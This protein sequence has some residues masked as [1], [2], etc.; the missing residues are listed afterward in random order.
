MERVILIAGLL[1]LATLDLAGQSGFVPCMPFGGQAAVD[2]L[3]ERELVFPEDALNE[4]VDGT[5]TLIFVVDADGTVHD[6]RVWQPLS[7]SCDAEALRL[8][9]LVRWHPATLDGQPRAA[10]HYLKVPFD[11]KHYR[12]WLKSRGALCPPLAPAPVDRSGAILGRNDVDSLPSPILPGGSKSLPAHIVQ[13]LRYPQD[14]YR[15]DLQG[16]VRLEFIVETSGSISNLRALDELGAGCTDEAMRLI[17]S[18]C[19][20]PAVKDG[21]RV[22][23]TQVISID[24]RIAPNQH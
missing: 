8:A 11:P 18:L 1:G 6:L 10:E 15:R 9:R 12:K 5:S 4:G 16:T 24:F 21:K 13:N 23:G 20:E 22:R 14:A 3:F 17:R 2:A 19:W 7:P